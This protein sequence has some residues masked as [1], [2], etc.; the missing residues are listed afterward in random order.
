MVM[1]EIRIRSLNCEDSVVKVGTS[2]GHVIVDCEVVPG[3]PCR[4][5]LEIHDAVMLA[6]YL[7]AGLRRMAGSVNHD[8]VVQK[9]S[10]LYEVRDV[11]AENMVARHLQ[12]APP[13]PPH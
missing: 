6:E 1:R 5:Q 9:L 10:E 3:Q 4:I 13:V 11:V 12:Q 7:T 8:G 2:E